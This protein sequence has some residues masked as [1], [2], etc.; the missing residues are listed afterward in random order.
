MRI[1]AIA[2]AVG[3]LAAA[4][5]STITPPEG[6]VYVPAGPF[7]MGSNVGDT[8]ESPE[9][10]ATTKAFFIDRY[11]VGNADFKK[12]EPTYT[13]K[14][15]YDNHACVVTWEQAAAYAKWAGK[16]LPTEEEWEKAARGTDARLYPWGDSWDATFVA[17]DETIPRG[18]T[19]MHAASPF[20]CLDMAG[21]VREWTD[22]WYKPYA[23]NEVPCESYG[24]QFKVCR[25]GSHFCD[26][27]SFR[28]SH[29]F[30]LP[31]NTTGNY[32]TGFRCVKDPE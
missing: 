24:E 17:W 15:G 25:G 31:T 29:R 19:I 4:P 5:T 18:G 27:F 16:R 2:L 26:P 11:E 10:L 7:R 23:G 28:S 30:Y 3:L 12:F 13:Y 21:G 14:D 22:S 9:H 1:A 32:S 8:D 6:M 20:G